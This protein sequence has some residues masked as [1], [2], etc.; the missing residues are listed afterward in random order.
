LYVTCIGLSF[1]TGFCHKTSAKKEFLLHA[2]FLIRHTAAV[3]KLKEVKR[4]RRWPR[5]D[6][7]MCRPV[8]IACRIMT[9][10][11]EL[12]RTGAASAT[13]TSA[14]PFA[15]PA[16][17]VT[18]FLEI[19]GADP[20][21]LLIYIGVAINATPH[22]LSV[23]IGRD[24]GKHDLFARRAASGRESGRLDFGYA[25]ELNAKHLKSRRL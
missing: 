19:I 12:P 16:Y 10:P 1:F 7:K 21:K 18:K 3:V 22:L 5:I 15:W 8:L 23:H 20:L 17:A 14:G 24:I 2:A 9:M 13:P 11:F 6:S 25:H 4:M